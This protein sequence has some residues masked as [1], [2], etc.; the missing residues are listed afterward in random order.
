[1][2]R[3]FFNIEDHVPDP[4]KDGQELDGPCQARAMAVVFAG[5]MLS[6][7]PE[8]LDDGAV[9]K[10]DVRDEAGRNVVLIPITAEAGSGSA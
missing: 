9:L 7:Q 10:V 1:M 8:L 5:D 2:P 4:D 3:Y 6:D